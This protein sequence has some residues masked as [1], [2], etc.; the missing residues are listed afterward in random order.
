MFKH[1]KGCIFWIIQ[2]QET[3]ETQET[4]VKRVQDTGSRS[5]HILLALVPCASDLASLGLSF[6]ICQMAVI[7][8]L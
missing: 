4:F 6:L 3:H 5:S 2:T 8:S 1:W 7:P